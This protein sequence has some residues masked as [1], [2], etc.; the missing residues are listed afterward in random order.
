MIH[1]ADL[2]FDDCGILMQMIASSTALCAFFV[3]MHEG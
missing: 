1:K 2:G 3:F